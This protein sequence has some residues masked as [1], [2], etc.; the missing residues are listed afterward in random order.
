MAQVAVLDDN[1]QEYP[2]D[3]PAI[4][5]GAIVITGEVMSK[6]G[7]SCLVRHATYDCPYSYTYYPDL[8]I[9]YYEENK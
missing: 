1:L 9:G 6:W 7:A 5:S 8:T 4:H 2:N 3:K